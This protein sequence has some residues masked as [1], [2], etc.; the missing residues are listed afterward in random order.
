[1]AQELAAEYR[2]RFGEIYDKLPKQI[3]HRNMNLSYVYL[4]GE[5]MIGVT[6]FD[7]SEYSIRLFDMC[8]AATGILS[9]NFADTE[10]NMQ[11]WLELYQSIVKGYDEVIGLTKEEK[12][13]LPYV[14]FSI[15][16]ICVA[17]FADK[18]EFTELAKINEKML[19]RLMEY[20]EKLM[21][22]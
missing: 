22:E 8:Y 21:I 10:E 2:S 6:D 3:I 19:V 18:E 17:Y 12:Q 16:L 11:K 14:V 1:M 7:L 4:N 9:E 15:Q 5:E 13:A 20:R